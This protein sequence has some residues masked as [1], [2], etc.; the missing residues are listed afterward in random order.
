MSTLGSRIKSAREQKGLLQSELAKLI[1]VKSAGVISNWEKD[2][3]KPDAEKIV[4]LC[5]ALDISASYLLDYYGKPDIELNSSEINLLKNYRLLDKHGKTIIDTILEEEMRR[6]KELQQ[7]ISPSSVIAMPNRLLQYYQHL[8]SAGN[9]EYLFDD[10]PADLIAAPDTPISRKADFVIG[11]SG[12]SMAPTYHDGDKV[13]V[14]KVDKIPVGSIGIF[15][16]GTECFIKEL[17]SNCLISHN[18]EYP[19]IPASEDIRL[20]GKV[21]GKVEDTRE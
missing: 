3:N 8:A 9:G 4:R 2:L 5:S 6:L 21:L 15:V 11:V 18:K 20:V 13:Y 17:G 19:D 14:Q 16:R 7:S 10:I 12:D 1:S